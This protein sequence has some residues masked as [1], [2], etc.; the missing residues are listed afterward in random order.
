[1]IAAVLIFGLLA[2][3]MNTWILNAGVLRWY[4]QR[5]EKK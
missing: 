1:M 4:I 3:F 2:D 5:G